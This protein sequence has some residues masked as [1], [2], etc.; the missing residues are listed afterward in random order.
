MS[1][2]MN[3]G[4]A[5]EAMKSGCKVARKGWNG[6]GQFAYYVPPASYPAQTGVAQAHFGE[7][8]MVPYRGYL[9]LKTAQEDVATWAPSCSDAL[10][11]DWVI[12]A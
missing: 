1:E 9:A 12:V 11:E 6:H 7:S 10:A 3:F 4:G 2:N 5:I 8:A